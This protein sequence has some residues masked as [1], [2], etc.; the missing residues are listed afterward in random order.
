MSRFFLYR[1]HS[2]AW[3]LLLHFTADSVKTILGKKRHLEYQLQIQTYLN[4]NLEAIEAS[5]LRNL[6]FLAKTLN[7]VFINNAVTGSKEGKN[8]GNKVPF[9][10]LWIKEKLTKEC[11][12]I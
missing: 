3:L 8:M 11:N 7:Q 1:R 2:T 4:C 9:I 12:N 5:C 6:H 10:I